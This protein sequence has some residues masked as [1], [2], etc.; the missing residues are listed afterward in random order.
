MWGDVDTTESA[1]IGLPAGGPPEV[2]LKIFINYR[3]E[4]VPFAAMTVYRELRRP[5]GQENIFFDHGTLRPGMRFPEEIRS[6]LTNGS[7]AFIA[8][9]GSLWVPTMLAHRQQGDLDY[10]AKELE[11]ALQNN[12]TVIPVLVDNASFP[13]RLQLPPAIRALPDCQAAPLRQ[14]NLDD[15]IADLT[16]RLNEIHQATLGRASRPTPV[17]SGVV[18]TQPSPKLTPMRPPPI[19]SPPADR[20][21]STAP[22]LTADAEHYQMLIEEADN[23][24]VFLGAEANADDHDG[25]YRE[26]A[27]MLPDDTDLAD[28]LAAKINLQSGQRD[29]AE[30][31]QYVRMIKGEPNVFRW[32]KQL[33]GVDSTPGPVHRYLARLP[34]RLDELGLGKRYQ[35]IVTPKLDLALEKAFRDEKEPFDVAVYMAGGT[36]YAGRF[37][38][39]PWGETDP[40]PIMS[41]ND[42]FGFP[43]AADSGELTR[44]VIVR[45]SGGVDDV[46]MGYRW[47]SN[48]VITEDHYIDY[49][50]GRP[51]EEVVPTQIL[52]KL[53]DASCLFLGYT[54][55]DWRLR[56]FLRWI[57]L[58][59]R[60]GRAT[61]WAVER[62]PDSLERQFWQRSGVGL[63]K[64]RLSDYVQGLDTFLQAIAPR[65]P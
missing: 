49:L 16:A 9:I 45:I 55:A 18:T 52:A 27:A 20:V 36:E 34:K 11:L 19:T 26:G 39:L 38:H 43:I 12:W 54:I 25:P 46:D 35:M 14:T 44:T 29:L 28:Y 23:L 24:V 22:V 60:L 37:V 2:P 21:E 40:R 57:W 17:T 31:A 13:D 5:F 42:Y 3:H 32:V 41:P 33:L 65:S 53:R 1:H 7:G 47:K 62:N 48:F 8:M 6:S 50:R 15:D 4:D 58:D 59:D 51:A 63:Y 61:H 10:V 64:C 56:V 30:I